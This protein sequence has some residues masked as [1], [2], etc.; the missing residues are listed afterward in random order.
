MTVVGGCGRALPPQ[1]VIDQLCPEVRDSVR[2]GKLRSCVPQ[3]SCLPAQVA[4]GGRVSAG[5]D[6]QTFL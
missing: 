2:Q 3:I 6:A 1:K 4:E 5:L